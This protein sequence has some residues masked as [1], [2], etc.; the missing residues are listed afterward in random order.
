MVAVGSSLAPICLAPRY[1]VDTVV[2][3]TAEPSRTGPDLIGPDQTKPD[4]TG[5]F[6]S[7]PSHPSHLFIL[8]PSLNDDIFYTLEGRYKVE[9]GKWKVEGCASMRFCLVVFFR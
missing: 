6:Y 2:I 3:N 8:K 1:V 7:Y 5:F 9:S 4:Q